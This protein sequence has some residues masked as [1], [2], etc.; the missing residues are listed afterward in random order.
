[1]KMQR[2]KIAL[3]FLFVDGFESI[4]MQIDSLF[5][6]EST[7]AIGFAF[8]HIVKKLPAKKHWH[9]SHA[10]LAHFQMVFRR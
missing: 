8:G 2:D 6:S 9:S 5:S 7:G 4:N 1:M 10:R 3:I